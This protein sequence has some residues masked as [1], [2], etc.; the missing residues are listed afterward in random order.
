MRG[1]LAAMSAMRTEPFRASVFGQGLLARMRKQRSLAEGHGRALSPAFWSDWTEG[2]HP[3][4]RPAASAAVRADGVRLHSHVGALNSSMVFAFNLFLPFRV[5]DSAPL[6]TLLSARLGRRVRVDRVQFEYTGPLAVLGETRSDTLAKREPA[7]AVDVAVLVTDDG[8]RQGLVLIEVKLSESGFS[9]CNGAESA[10]N[11]H[12]APCE[13]AAKFL[14]DPSACYLRRPKRASRD[15]RYWTIFGNACGSLAAAF[16]GASREGGCPFRGDLQQ[17]MRNHALLLGIVQAGI[18]EFGAIM[19]VH[20]DGNP[21][22]V[23]P[24]EAYRAMVADSRCVLRMPASV[25]T[26]AADAGLDARPALSSWLRERYC[27]EGRDDV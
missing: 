3:A 21:D 23:G 9:V 4:V 24:W 27:L 16:P 26:G 12:R 11:L 20:H 13:S 2:L 17:P 25:V 18:A 22:V 5:G 6:A 8:G 15:R 7:T 19:L 10:G 14:D 1:K